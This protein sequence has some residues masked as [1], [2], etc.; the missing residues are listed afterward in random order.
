MQFNERSVLVTI[1]VPG[2]FLL[3]AERWSP[4]EV[5][6][7]KQDIEREK[8]SNEDDKAAGKTP[9]IVIPHIEIVA[10]REME[11]QPR[12]YNEFEGGREPFPPRISWVDGDVYYSLDGLK[13]SV[14]TVTLDDLK[15]VVKSMYPKR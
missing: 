2:K 3:Y 11:I 13:E 7:L 1:A 5:P 10:G 14:D 9:T 15:K 6:D 12:G 8:L 4:G